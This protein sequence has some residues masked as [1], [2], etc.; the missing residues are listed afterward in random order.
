MIIVLL[1]MPLITGIGLAA[2]YYSRTCIPL[3]IAHNAEIQCQLTAESVYE[4]IAADAVVG[5]STTLFDFLT[6]TGTTESVTTSGPD[7]FTLNSQQKYGGLNYLYKQITTV[8]TTTSG[9]FFKT[10]TTEV[11]VDV[12]VR[13][14][15]KSSPAWDD[16]YYAEKRRLGIVGDDSGHDSSFFFF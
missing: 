8:T 11:Q 7:P 12:T 1:L 10:T 5:S 15:N 2:Y 13:A 9:F 3:E 14:Y 6:P 4:D 16:T